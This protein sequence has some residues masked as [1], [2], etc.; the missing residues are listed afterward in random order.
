MHCI[1]CLYGCICSC[2]TACMGMC[3]YLCLSE[4]SCVCL[5]AWLFAH[6]PLCLPLSLFYLYVW[7]CVLTCVWMPGCLLIFHSASIFHSFPV[8]VP[9]PLPLSGRT[10]V[11]KRYLPLSRAPANRIKELRRW[12]CSHRLTTFLKCLTAIN[13]LSIQVQYF[14]RDLWYLEWTS[15]HQFDSVF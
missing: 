5:N 7:V 9:P 6:F 14:V 15:H 11:H 3:A 2:M 1:V 12:V 13:Y 4:C 10:D 8:C